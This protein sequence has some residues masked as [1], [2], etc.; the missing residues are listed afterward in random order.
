MKVGKRTVGIIPIKMRNTRLPGKNIKPLGEGKVLCQYLFNTL[1]NVKQIDEIYVYCSDEQIKE[2]MPQ[3]IRFLKRPQWLD[4]DTVKSRDI[5]HEFIT[6]IHADIYALMH[7]TQPFLTAAHIDEVVRKVK[8]DAYD[9]GFVAREIK[10]FAWYGGRPVNYSLK[11]VVRTQDLHPVYVEGELFVFE[12][13]VFTVLGRRIGE[14]PYIQPITWEESIC[15]DDG[16]D[17][18]MAQA[19]L[20]LHQSE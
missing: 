15:I 10:E 11:D 14:N 19:V 16:E 8:N 3:G 20:K 4:E 17:F 5:L 6:E 18:R 13:E 9:S 1:G 12:K 2:Y 7:V